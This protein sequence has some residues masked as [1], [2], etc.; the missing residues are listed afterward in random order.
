MKKITLFIVSLFLAV[1][2]VSAQTPDVKFN[3]VGK[4]QFEA[5][6]APPEYSVGNVEIALNEA[7][8]AATMIFTGIDFKL[9]GDKVVFENNTLKFLI[10]VE[11]MDVSIILNQESESKMTGKAVHSEGEIPITLTKVPEKE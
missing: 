10:Y 9:P 4:W 8:Y 7:K 2:A 6:Y 5:P 1:S 3:P 11:G